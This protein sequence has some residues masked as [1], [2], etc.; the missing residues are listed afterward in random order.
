MEFPV[1]KHYTET[2]GAYLKVSWEVSLVVFKLRKYKM[3]FRRLFFRSLR[4]QS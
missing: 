4:V 3:T 1:F 2:T